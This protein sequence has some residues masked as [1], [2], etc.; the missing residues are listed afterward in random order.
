LFFFSCGKS[1]FF[2]LREKQSIMRTLLTLIVVVIVASCNTAQGFPRNVVIDSIAVHKRAHKMYLFE[3]GRLIGVYNIALGKQ[4][5]GPK[6]TKGDCKTP[7]G[8]YYINDKNPNSDYYMNLGIS[9]PNNEDRYI[10]KRMGRSPG[11]DIK[12]HGMP[13]GKAYLGAVHTASDWTLG[14][15]A[16]TNEQMDELFR[17][18]EVG[19]PIKIIP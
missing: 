10:A 3:E 5:V 14:C 2:D 15:I 18:V 9:Y 6:R 1:E 16:I 17:H 11:G 4:P 13:N 7:E 8:L 19:T 12:I